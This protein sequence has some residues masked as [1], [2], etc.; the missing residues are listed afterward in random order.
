MLKP[1]GKISDVFGPVKN[2]YISVKSMI[3]ELE[4]YVG[5]PL[6]IMNKNEKVK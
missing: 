3:N 4:Y 5:R 1:V 2:P 6:Y